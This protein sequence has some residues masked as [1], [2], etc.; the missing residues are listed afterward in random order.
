MSFACPVRDQRL[1][2]EHVVGIGA[3]GVDLDTVDAVLDGAAALA[4]GEFAPLA[5]IGD[6]VGARWA[7]GAVT[8][9]DGFKAAYR[10]F[11]QGGWMGLAAPEAAGGQGLPLSLAA[12]L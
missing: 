4:E 7:D 9:P 2:L 3:L 10:G 11:A 5:R 8:M 1:V 6:S 12:A